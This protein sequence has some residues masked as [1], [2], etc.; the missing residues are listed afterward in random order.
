MLYQP[1][2]MI[3]GCPWTPPTWMKTPH[4]YTGA[5]QF[6][7]TAPYL[8]AYAMYFRKFVQAWQN[9]GIAV[10]IVYP[11]NEPEWN[12][13]GQPACGWTGTQLKDFLKNYVYPD[14][15]ANNV[16]TQLWLGNFMSSSSYSADVAPAMW[17][18]T[19]IPRR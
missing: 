19:G 5:A 11:Q 3:Y 4:Q 12:V 13:G 6:I 2:V 15:K 9:C 1:N 10:N 8:T 18:F 14:F 16:N 7:Q 17:E